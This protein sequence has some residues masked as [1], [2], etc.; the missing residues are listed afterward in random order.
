MTTESNDIEKAAM[1]LVMVD[2]HERK[3]QLAKTIFDSAYDNGAYS[4]SIMNFIWLAAGAN[5][6]VS[7][8]PR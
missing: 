8:S 6:A 4:A 5:S 3:R 1:E 2:D 7:Q